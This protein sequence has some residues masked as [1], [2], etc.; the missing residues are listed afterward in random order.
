MTKKKIA[1]DLDD[2]LADSTEFWRVEINKRTN[3]NLSKEHYR[4]PGA[5]WQYYENV[6]RTHKI[7]HLISIPDIDE[8]MTKDQSG[9]QA[10]ADSLQVL[11]QLSEIY[12][13]LVVTARNSDQRQETEKWLNTNFPDIFKNIYF[14]DGQHGLKKKNKGEICKEIG[15][16]WLIDD[17]PSHCKDALDEG[18]SVVVFG[19]YGWHQD[20]PSGAV[21]CKDWPAVLEYFDGQC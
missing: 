9:I 19:E 4:V 15:A 1:F 8:Q 11:K 12:S 6:W 3:Q 20:V 14:A 17:N 18:I 5:Y 2:V 16:S 10:Y 21:T 13:L 7:D